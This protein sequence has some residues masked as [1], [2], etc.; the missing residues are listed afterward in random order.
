[1][2]AEFCGWKI[3][4]DGAGLVPGTEVPDVPRLLANLFRSTSKEAV[5]AADTERWRA[6]VAASL[7]SRVAGIAYRVPSIANWAMDLADELA[8]SHEMEFTREDLFRLG[9]DLGDVLPE[10]WKNDD[11]VR[12]IKE[13]LKYGH[14]ADN[15]RCTISNSVAA[16]G[17]ATEISLAVRHGWVSDEQEWHTFIANLRAVGLQTPSAAFCSIVPPGML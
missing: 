3:V 1:M 10:Y 4:V 15:V 9:S 11:P 7:V 17:I 12:I 16:G 6:I 13:S 14:Y 8:V 2:V 5:A